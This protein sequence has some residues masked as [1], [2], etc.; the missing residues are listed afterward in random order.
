VDWFR[1]EWAAIMAPAARIMRSAVGWWEF[2]RKNKQRMGKSFCQVDRI[3]HIGQDRPDITFGN[4]KWAGAAPALII[5][6]S[7]MNHLGGRGERAGL[8]VH[9]PPKIRADAPRIWASR[10]FVA[11]SCS[12]EVLS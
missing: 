11:D 5:R 1:P 4:Q 12:T 9:R 10:Y 6:P 3:R 2:K 7:R 8:S